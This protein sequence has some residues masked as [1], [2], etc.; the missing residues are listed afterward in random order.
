[1]RTKRASDFTWHSALQAYTKAANAV[2]N[3]VESCEEEAALIAPTGQPYGF[4]VL[5]KVV[6]VRVGPKKQPAVPGRPRESAR[7]RKAKATERE[8]Q[9]C[10]R[11]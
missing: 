6:R 7:P 4:Q 5:V 2:A 1:M 9:R 8:G 10:R 3:G 11:R